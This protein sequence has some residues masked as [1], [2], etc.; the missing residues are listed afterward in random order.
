MSSTLA[1]SLLA[2]YAEKFPSSARLY[3]RGK[4]LFPNGVTHDARFMLPF[5][6][7]IERAAG[8]KK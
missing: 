6:V 5:P 7:Y 8:S 1:P 3:E 2:A 4:R